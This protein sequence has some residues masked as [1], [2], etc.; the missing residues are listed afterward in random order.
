MDNQ[1]TV[2]FVGLGKLGLACAEVMSQCYD[3]SG[4]DI[5][6]R[7]SD[8]IKILDSLA[9]TVSGKDIIFIAVQTPHDPVYDGSQPITHL[10]NKDFDYTIVKQVLADINQYV[11]ENQLVV[12][13]STVLPGTTRRDLRACITNARF[14][15]NPYLIAMG[16]VEWDMVNPEMVILGTE[17]GDVTTDAALM[18]D[19]YAPLMQNNPRYAVGTW[20]EAECIKI[21]YNTF[22]SA[23]LSL[24]NMIQDV[25]VKNGNINVDVVTTALANANIRITSGK[26]MTAGMGDAGPC[27]PR[28]NIALRH[29]SEQLDLGYDIFDT[30]MMARERQAENLA[31]FLIDLQSQHNL[32]IVIH[33]KAY[34]PN[35]DILD[36]SYSL[37]IGH[38]LNKNTAEFTYSDLLT[39]DYVAD[40]TRAIVLLAHNQQITYGYT[41]Q[42]T[43][44]TLYFRLG[45][46]S[47][48]VDPWRKFHSNDTSIIVI[49]YGN[50][51]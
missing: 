10:P 32:P 39:G 23:K 48:V 14:I 33:G 26:Y 36:G 34:K 11:N 17:D 4:Y 41:G 42:D 46:N 16:S 31:E 28:D 49:H 1:L 25:A 50:T 21:F 29:L 22:I 44:Q 2:G 35:V 37:L 9:D 45:Q 7:S 12:L 30:I 38:Y 43:E 6:P 15:Y 47:V 18:R 40:N 13:I 8:K 3:V 19:F 24:V 51:R 5:Y 27:H 20:D